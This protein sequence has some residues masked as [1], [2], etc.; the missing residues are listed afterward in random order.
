[1]KAHTV[2]DSRYLDFRG[3]P[4]KSLSIWSPRDYLCEARGKT[5]TQSHTLHTHGRFHCAVLGKE[6]A[7]KD[8]SCPK[9]GKMMTRSSLYHHL[10]KLVF[11]KSV[12]N[13]IKHY[14]KR[15]KEKQWVVGEPQQ[16]IRVKEKL[17]CTP[18]IPEKERRTGISLLL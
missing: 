17:K 16:V 13:L 8:A 11:V 7:P 9:C 3:R 10:S 14:Q 2:R 15:S 6:K 4:K 1:M 18:K 12:L 5:F